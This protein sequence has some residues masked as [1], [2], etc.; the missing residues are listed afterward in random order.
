MNNLRCRSVF[1]ILSLNKSILFRNRI[2]GG[3][4]VVMV[5]KED[6]T[7]QVTIE[8]LVKNLLLQIAWKR[9]RDSSSRF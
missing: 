1:D 4:R 2:C 7:R 8:V 5:S 9:F 3:K 6:T